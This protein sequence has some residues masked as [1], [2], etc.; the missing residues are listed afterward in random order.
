MLSPADFATEEVA[1]TRIK[2][3]AADT[4]WLA[5]LLCAVAG[6][7][8]S[9]ERQVQANTPPG[10]CMTLCTNI[11][12]NEALQD[13]LNACVNGAS[14]VCGDNTGNCSWNTSST[15]PGS[16]AASQ[17]ACTSLACGNTPQGPC[18]RYCKCAGYATGSMNP[19]FWMCHCTNK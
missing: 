6:V 4:C 5:G 1:M 18:V 19:P 10:Q 17:N 15:C 7:L 2:L 16:P 9:V 11:Q 13:C 14:Y 12:D 8:I 3:L